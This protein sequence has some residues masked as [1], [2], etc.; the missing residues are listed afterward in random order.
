VYC[1]LPVA[2]MAQRLMYDAYQV[3]SARAA[4]RLRLIRRLPAQNFVKH[5]TKLFD[6][7]DVDKVALRPR[8]LRR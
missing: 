6:L 4:V 7:D 2:Q 5:K 1:T 3:P 8:A